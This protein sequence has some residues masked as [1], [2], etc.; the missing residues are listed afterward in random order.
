M[1]EYSEHAFKS[2]CAESQ[3]HIPNM[4]ELL[5]EFAGAN[6]VLNW[7]VGFRASGDLQ[8]MVFLRESRYP[9][10]EKEPTGDLLILME[11]AV[12]CRD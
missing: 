8:L 4:E 9:E 12:R 5:I 1:I 2:L 3:P 7:N 11:P 10:A 6:S